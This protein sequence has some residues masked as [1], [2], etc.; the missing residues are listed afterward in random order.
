MGCDRHPGRAA[1]RDRTGEGQFVDVSMTDGAL[2]CLALDAAASSRGRAPRAA[3]SADRPARLLPPVPLPRRLALGRGLEP[4]F[5]H[6]FCASSTATPL[7]GGFD[8]PVPRTTCAVEAIG[9]AQDARRMGRVRRRARRL[10]RAGP[11][12]RRGARSRSWCASARWSSRST[13]PAGDGPG[14]AGRIPIKLSATPGRR[15]PAPGPRARR[16]HH[17]GPARARVRQRGDPRAVRGR[18]GGGAAGRGAGVVPGLRFVGAHC[19]A[20]LRAKRGRLGFARRPG[21]DTG[22]A[23]TGAIAPVALG[24]ER[25][26]FGPIWGFKVERMIP[27]RG[28][29]C[30]LRRRSPETFAPHGR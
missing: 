29:S 28:A 12:P 26:T 9:A 5:W 27:L 17:R 14:P 6:A 24:R 21:T 8:P 30:P 3:A 13:V 2:A 7:E 11:R 4:K 10:R 15:G 23:G 20:L 16:A 22:R 19:G 18:G 25:S 1:R